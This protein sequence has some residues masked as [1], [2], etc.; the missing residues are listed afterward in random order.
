[1]RFTTKTHSPLMYVANMEAIQS[2]ML[3]A[4]MAMPGCG[5]GSSRVYSSEKKRLDSSRG[6]AGCWSPKV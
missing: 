5:K 1:V 3:L 2:M 6:L 4:C